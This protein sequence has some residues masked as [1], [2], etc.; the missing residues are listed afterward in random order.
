VRQCRYG[1]PAKIKQFCLS[2][3]T[4]QH[5]KFLKIYF[6][7]NKY[8][9]IMCFICNNFCFLNNVQEV[10]KKLNDTAMDSSEDEQKAYP[11]KVTLRLIETKMKLFP[12]YIFKREIIL[13]LFCTAGAQFTDKRKY[14]SRITIHHETYDIK[15]AAKGTNSFK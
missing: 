12:L 2:W 15:E 5:G 9:K 3:K 6:T 14:R 13:Y 1:C 7:L 8:V 10:E 11:R 4:L